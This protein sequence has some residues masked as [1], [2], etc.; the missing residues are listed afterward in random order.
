M[1]IHEGAPNCHVHSSGCT[2]SVSFPSTTG[3]PRSATRKLRAPKLMLTSQAPPKP[4]ALVCTN[5]SS[6]S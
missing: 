1:F 4:T 6:S 5:T 3:W 2:A